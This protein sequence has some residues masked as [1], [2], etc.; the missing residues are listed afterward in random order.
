MNSEEDIKLF[1][2]YNQQFPETSIQG[3]YAVSNGQVYIG[4][5]QILSC[6]LDTVF[7]YVKLDEN[8]KITEWN[9]DVLGNLDISKTKEL[10]IINGKIGGDIDASYSGIEKINQNIGGN[11][12]ISHTKYFKYLTVEV[13]G[14]VNAFKSRLKKITKDIGGDLDIRRTKF[15][16]SLDGKVGGNVDARRSNIKHI[17]QNIG[18]D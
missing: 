12:N 8:S 18:G 2:E 7:D 17:N 10:S 11:L 13:G 15:F 16:K 3:S 6:P 5:E 1:P 14:N 9:Y 4:D